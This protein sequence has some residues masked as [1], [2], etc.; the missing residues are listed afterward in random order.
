[1]IYI[2]L[3]S[4]SLGCSTRKQHFTTQR[5][6]DDTAFKKKQ[7]TAGRYISF[8]FLQAL[9]FVNISYPQLETLLQI[10]Y[11]FTYIY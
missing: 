6:K 3:V 2:E 9:A 5:H 4:F 10:M 7:N 1:M 8:F 11:T